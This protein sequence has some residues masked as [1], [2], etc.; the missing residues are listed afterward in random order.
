[1]QQTFP[2]KE[3]DVIFIDFKLSRILFGN[4]SIRGFVRNAWIWSLFKSSCEHTINI[5]ETIQVTLMQLELQ[6]GPFPHGYHETKCEHLYEHPSFWNVTFIPLV[7][8]LRRIRP[9][10]KLK[11]MYWTPNITTPLFCKWKW[12]FFCLLI[13]FKIWS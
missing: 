13:L 3:N 4:W 12:K 1:M 11:K 7:H 8:N 9:R 6:H 10:D 2:P 5:I